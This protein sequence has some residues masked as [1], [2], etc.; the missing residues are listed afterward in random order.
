LARRRSAAADG[1]YIL[2]IKRWNRSHA[3]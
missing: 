2:L 1:I 3:L